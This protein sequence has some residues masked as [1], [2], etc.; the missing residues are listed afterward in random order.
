MK[1]LKMLLEERDSKMGELEKRTQA[2]EDRQREWESQPEESRGP[3]PVITDDEDKQVRK[4][5]KDID[6][7][8]ARIKEESKA[9]KR[10]QDIAEA[11]KLIA[12]ATSAD[13]TVEVVAEPMVYGEGSPNSYVADLC[14]R[15]RAQ[16]GEPDFGA[17]GRLNKWA[18]QV[19][20]EIADGSKQGKIAEKQ[21]RETYRTMSPE[22][23]RAALAEHRDRGRVAEGDK[24][25]EIRAIASGG[26]ATASAASGGAAFVTP[27]FF[28]DKYAPYREYGRSFIDQCNK[29]PL[30]DYGMEVYIPYVSS[31]AG[32]A[33]QNTE[34]TGVQETDPGFGYKSAALITEAGQ[35]TVSQQLLDRAGPN[36]SFDQ[37]IFDQLMR[38]YAPKVDTYTLTQTLAVCATQNWTGSSGAFDLTTTSGAGG[39]YGQ[40]SKA[41]AAIR[42]SAGTVMNPTHLFLDPRIWEFMA[43]WSDSTGRPIVVPGYAQ[44]FNAAAAGNA[45]GDEG[46][47]GATGYRFNGLPVF[48]DANIPATGT[49]SNSSALVGNLAEVFVYEGSV[50]PRVIPQTYANQLQTLLQIYA[51]IAVVIR[52]P[53][54]VV[55]IYG[56]PFNTS[57]SYTN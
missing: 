18:H 37:M 6:A 5:A 17:I 26:G 1:V 45:S 52:Y 35:V 42:T 48:A 50:V 39:F 13:A 16:H 31:A 36:F 49:T 47:E 46:I 2:I 11:R 22:A 25:L 9:E 28:V 44:P 53:N 38:D 24:D 21:L 29:Q 20:R 23:A 8:D 54:S 4:L 55:Q 12:D 10:R 32:V 43:A 27:L 57:P 3:E 30:P 34:G 14:R 56:T 19:E 7:L 41:K 40:V 33:Q 51:Y 15:V